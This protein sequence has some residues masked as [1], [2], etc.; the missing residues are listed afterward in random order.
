VLNSGLRKLVILDR[1]GGRFQP[2]EIVVGPESDGYAAVSDGLNAG[3]RVVTS[4]Q[5]LIDS[6]SNLHEALGAMSLAP[7]AAVSPAAAQT[8]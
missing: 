3:D 5:F 8:R 2:R 7:A 6:E 1:G 4:A